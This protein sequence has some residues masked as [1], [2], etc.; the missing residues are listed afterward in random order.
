MAHLFTNRENQGLTSLAFKTDGPT[1]TPMRGKNMTTPLRTGRKAFGV[2]N[3]Q[4][5]PLLNKQE[6]KTKEV[7]IGNVLEANVKCEAKEEDYPEIEKVF[8][9]DP[10][11]FEKYGD[12][13]DLICLGSLPLAGLV[14]PKAPPPSEEDLHA[15]I[16]PLPNTSPPRRPERFEFDAFLQ[17]IDELTVELPSEPESDQFSPL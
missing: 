8:P 2:V 12:P 5:T 15:Y 13:E 17:T 4:S 9:Y 11:E 14:F 3:T 7:K 6:K 16:P 10:L 1:K